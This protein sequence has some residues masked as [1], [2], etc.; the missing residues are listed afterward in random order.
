M[1]EGHYVSATPAVAKRLGLKLVGDA[2]AS[3][4]R[5]GH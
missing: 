1:I 4:L 3:T 2:R 5:E